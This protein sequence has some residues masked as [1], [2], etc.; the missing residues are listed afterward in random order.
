M[1]NI[2]RII[3]SFFIP[4]FGIILALAFLT[5]G[6]W[7]CSILIMGVTLWGLISII[8]NRRSQLSG[9]KHHNNTVQVRENSMPVTYTSDIKPT[10][11]KDELELQLEDGKIVFDEE[12]AM[13]GFDGKKWWDMKWV[14][15]PNLFDLMFEW[16]QISE[17]RM[18]L[19][20]KSAYGK[21]GTNYAPR[22]E[23]GNIKSPRFYI[24]GGSPSVKFVTTF[25]GNVIIEFPPK[26]HVEY[27]QEN[28]DKDFC[29]YLVVKSQLEDNSDVLIVDYSPEIIEKHQKEIDD[30][31]HERILAQKRREIEEEKRKIKEKLRKEEIRKQAEIELEEEGIL[32]PEAAK[33]EPI[34]KEVRDFVWRRDGGRCVEC[35]STTNLQFDHIIPFSKGGATTV[36]NLQILCQKCNIRKSNHIG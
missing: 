22:V 8:F 27:L 3:L 20:Y 4:L 17:F 35:G 34:P 1:N 14:R 21:D 18:K 6:Q 13:N 28:T 25:F 30:E 32:Y 5:N 24:W 19:R 9:K 2:L 33:R 29:G 16:V 31:L 11:Q 10:Q 15:N 7:S 26:C 23:F 36:E 12:R